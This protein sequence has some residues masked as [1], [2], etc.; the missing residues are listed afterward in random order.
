[1]RT[2]LEED[3]RGFAAVFE[4][5]VGMKSV[6]GIDL[7]RL[8]AHGQ[9]ADFRVMVRPHSALQALMEAMVP[10]I[11]RVLTDQREGLAP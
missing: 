1:V 11:E 6:E 2:F 9:V 7:I 5:K 8:D 10:A 3:G 4:A